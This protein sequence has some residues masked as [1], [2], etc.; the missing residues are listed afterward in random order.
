MLR[1]PLD[2]QRPAIHQD[3]HDGRPRRRDRLQQLLLHAGKADHRTARRFA[4]HFAALPKS[5]NS[6]LGLPCRRDRLGEA[7]GG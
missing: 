6:D 1:G 7:R 5:Q 2:R 3:E 4:A